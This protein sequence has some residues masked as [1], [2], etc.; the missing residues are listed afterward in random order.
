MTG[1]KQVEDAER[2]LSSG[3]QESRLEGDVPSGCLPLA[4]P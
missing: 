2:A 3:D 4:F 1:D